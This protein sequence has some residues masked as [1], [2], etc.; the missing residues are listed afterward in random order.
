MISLMTHRPSRTRRGSA[1]R[2][3][4]RAGLLAVGLACA[5]LVVSGS[6]LGATTAIHFEPES[7]SALKVQLGHHE[8]H[9]LSF[10]PAGSVGHIHVSLNGGRHMTVSYSSSEQAALVALA[11][12]DGTR[13]LVAT[14]KPKA[15]AKPVHH[16]LR[17]I[18]AGILVVVIVVVAAVL[19]IDRRRKL[20][21]GDGERAPESAPTPPSSPG[22]PT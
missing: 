11:H 2:A 12:T 8:V 4:R 14:A 5:C 18:A 17:Y 1:A 21:E 16:K 10:H 19:L 13:V 15:A 20:G 9:L 22:E 6:A 3:A 7:L